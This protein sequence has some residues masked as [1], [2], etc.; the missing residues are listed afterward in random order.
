M[1][2]GKRSSKGNVDEHILY[3]EDSNLIIL[4]VKNVSNKPHSYTQDLSK[5][6]FSSLSLLNTANPNQKFNKM[7]KY[8]IDSIK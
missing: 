8:E 3:H 1:E 7:L 5:I 6:N 2:N 4:T